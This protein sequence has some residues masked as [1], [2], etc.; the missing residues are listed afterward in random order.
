M[1]TKK[2]RTRRC[3]KGGLKVKKNENIRSTGVKGPRIDYRRNNVCPKNPKRDER[4]ANK[5]I[6][7]Y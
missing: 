2:W 1:G 5:C 4:I 3:L 6:N 7:M